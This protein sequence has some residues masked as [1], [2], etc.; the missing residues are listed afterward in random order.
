MTIS[1]G[2]STLTYLVRAMKGVRGAS[3]SC[4]GMHLSIHEV[5]IQ[6]TN[7]LRFSLLTSVMLIY[8]KKVNVL[9]HKSERD[10]R[11]NVGGGASRMDGSSY[12]K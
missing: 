6:D 7:H 2:P 1:A 12:P 4:T 10:A 11:L 9:P 5:S 8:Y 3:A